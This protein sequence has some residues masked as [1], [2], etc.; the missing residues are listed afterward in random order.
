M[1]ES[2]NF[3]YNSK[4]FAIGEILLFPWY[5]PSLKLK[6]ALDVIPINSGRVLEVGCGGG[7][8][9][10]GI[11]RY[12]PNLK[13]FGCDISTHSL[14]F[15]R[16]NP[17]GAKFYFGNI[18]HLPFKSNF[19]DVV[20]CIDVFEHLEDIPKALA[21]IKRVMKPGGLVHFAL[22]YEG[23]FFNLEGWLTHLGWRAKEIYCG[24]I[25]KFALGKPETIIANCN[26][27]LVERKFSYHLIAQIVDIIYFSFIAI[28]G[29]NFNFQIEGFLAEGKGPFKKLVWIARSIFSVITYLESYLLYW[30]P[31]LTGH[32]TFIKE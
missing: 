21:E 2:K 8:I 6:Y 29:K 28:R 12:K 20:F 24:H 9:A 5:I 11:K 13:V 32:L 15:A 16:K 18:Y 26:F 3:D 30:F 4:A 23:S 7:A 14:S 22:P 17:G 19:F 25:H 10:R 1:R 31:G 27:R